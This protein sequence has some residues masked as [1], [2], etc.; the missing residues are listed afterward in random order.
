[1]D[2]GFSEQMAHVYIMSASN[3]DVIFSVCKYLQ[4]CFKQRG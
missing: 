4:K 3:A 2:L 1:M